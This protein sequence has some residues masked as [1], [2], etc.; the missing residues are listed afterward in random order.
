MAKT[1]ISDR[2]EERRDFGVRGIGWWPTT[3]AP[4]MAAAFLI[5]FALAAVV[6]AIFGAGDRGTEL[7][8]QITARW[9]FLLFWLAYAGSG[10]ARLLGPHFGEL[11]RRGRELG[12]AFA[13][14][15]VLHVGLILWLFHVGT[16]P[17]GA[18][19]F[20]WV[21]ILCTYL[22]ALFSL[23]R[24]R[25]ALGPRLW[26]IFRTIALEYI[27]L[28]FARDFI[29]LPLQADGIGKYPLTYLPFALMLVGG[30]GV[31]IAAFLD[32]RLRQLREH[33]PR[34]IGGP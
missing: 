5:A 19:I 29:L 23:P 11:A 30:A 33:F 9:S 1:S 27:A 18:M 28:V 14:A 25:D 6:L 26:R 2:A 17:D 3:A 12:L 21:G 20:F 8:L 4:W 34:K 31:H 24:L 13:S 7:A 16:G 10:M 15:H 22:L 32:Q